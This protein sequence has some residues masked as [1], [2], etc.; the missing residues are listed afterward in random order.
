MAITWLEIIV[1]IR[2]LFRND[3]IGRIGGGVAIY[4]RT[5]ISYSILNTSQTMGSAHAEH[6]FIGVILRHTKLLLGIFYSPNFTVD[7]FSS[8][9]VLVDQ[10]MPSYE[11][12]L[13]MGVF[14][15]CLLKNDYRACCLQS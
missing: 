2:N 15:T 13:I 4:L 10:F 5:H 7:Y 3:R 11:R 1:L 12:T 8:L 6:L 14:N 9:E